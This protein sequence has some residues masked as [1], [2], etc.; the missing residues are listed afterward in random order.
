MFTRPPG[1][2]YINCCGISWP[3]STPSTSSALKTP[4]I[5][6][7]DPGDPEPTDGRYHSGITPLISCTTQV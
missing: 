6:E 2:S 7:E 5:T 1:M 4:E 3:L